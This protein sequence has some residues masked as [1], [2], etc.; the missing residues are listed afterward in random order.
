MKQR[1]LLP[2]AAILLASPVWASSIST[3]TSALSFNG[4]TGN[5]SSQPLT[6]TASGS[7]AVT[8]NALSFSNNAFS[9][10]WV[11][12]PVKLSPGQSLTVKVSAQPETTAMQGVLNIGTSAGNFAVALSE[13]AAP[14]TTAH[15]VN[16]KW[17]APSTGI[18]T[19]SYDVD[20]ANSGSTHFSHIGSTPASVTNWTDYSPQAGQTYQYRVR[21]LDHNGDTGPPSS[22][23]TLKIP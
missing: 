4:S 22:A 18:P 12:L 23:I 15:S 10:S 9:N 20:R 2:L 13:T 7:Q 16:L 21:A 17:G 11:T 1:F 8:V 19:G 5:V 14:S 6:I 3:S